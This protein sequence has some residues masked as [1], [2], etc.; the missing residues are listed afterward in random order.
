MDFALSEEQEMLKKTAR[1]FL[2]S[3]CPESVV[4]EVAKS[5][6]GYSSELWHKIAGLGWLGMVR[7]TV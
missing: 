3:N 4:R 6:K 1:D 5:D 2:E 7:D